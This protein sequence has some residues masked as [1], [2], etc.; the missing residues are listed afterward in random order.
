MYVES[1]EHKR[2]SLKEVNEWVSKGVAVREGKFKG[3]K[4]ESFIIS[5][6]ELYKCTPG[7]N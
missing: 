7:R 5:M 2:T 1:S 4:A 3:F 6:V